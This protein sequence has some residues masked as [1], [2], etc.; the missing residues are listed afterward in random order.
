MRNFAGIEDKYCNKE[1]ASVLLQPILYDGTCTW[2]K[3]A[4]KA[5]EA[6]LDALL[7]FNA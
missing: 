1:T 3:G 7:F 2:G 4:D 6:F 5:L